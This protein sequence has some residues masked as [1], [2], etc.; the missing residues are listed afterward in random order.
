MHL[1]SIF[2][3]WSKYTVSITLFYFFLILIIFASSF[4]CAFLLVLSGN[5]GISHYGTATEISITMSH[6]LYVPTT[7][8]IFQICIKIL[9]IC[10]NFTWLFPFVPFT[11]SQRWHVSNLTAPTEIR[12]SHLPDVPILLGHLLNI[13]IISVES[14]LLEVNN[15]KINILESYLD[16][17]FQVTSVED[18][19]INAYIM[20]FIQ[21]QGHKI[22][23]N[24][25]TFSC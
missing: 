22:H 12:W 2:I 13:P 5:Q 18:N 17:D 1:L 11:H 20:N 23:T 9:A 3:F 24:S 7:S 16:K 14:P 10:H 25:C 15:T 19:R 8:N 4:P 6:H 21:R